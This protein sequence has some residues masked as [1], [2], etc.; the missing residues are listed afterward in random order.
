M[1]EFDPIST[2]HARFRDPRRSQKVFGTEPKIQNESYENREEFS[3][4][5]IQILMRFWVIFGRK[6]LFLIEIDLILTLVGDAAGE[7]IGGLAA[8]TFETPL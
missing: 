6:L 4:I 7:I 8:G 5:Y 3:N 2:I 1:T